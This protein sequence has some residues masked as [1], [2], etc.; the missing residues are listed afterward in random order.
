VFVSLL[1]WN[2]VRLDTGT[3]ADPA[4]IQTMVIQNFGLVALLILIC[5]LTG[6]KP[7]WH[8]GDKDGTKSD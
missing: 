5:Y 8:W 2:S 1:V 3:P 6:E 7:G 4:A